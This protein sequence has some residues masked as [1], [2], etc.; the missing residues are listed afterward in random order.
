MNSRQIYGSDEYS[1]DSPSGDFKVVLIGDK[2]VYLRLLADSE[3]SS[4]KLYALPIED[5]VSIAYSTD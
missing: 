5:I 4:G 3:P 2:F 1:E